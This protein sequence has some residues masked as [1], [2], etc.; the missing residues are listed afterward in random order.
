MKQEQTI[1]AE[2]QKRE[3][4][5]ALTEQLARLDDADQRQ[6]MGF[7]QGIAY[8]KLTGKTA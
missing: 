5:E 1:K 8:A 6:V 3:V 7:A 2:E 4:S